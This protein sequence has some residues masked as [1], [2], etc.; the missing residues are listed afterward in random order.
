MYTIFL[1]LYIYEMYNMYAYTRACII[2]YMATMLLKSELKFLKMKILLPR[3][4]AVLNTTRKLEERV[5][6]II[7]FYVKTSCKSY[8]LKATQ[9]HDK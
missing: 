8:M 6:N 3:I 7:T 1:H 9:K 4:C 5:A 2:V